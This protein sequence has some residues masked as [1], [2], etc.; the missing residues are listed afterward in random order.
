[1]NECKF[2]KL[3]AIRVPQKFISDD[4]TSF[5]ATALKRVMGEWVIRCKTVPSY[6]SM[7]NG[8]AGRMVGTINRSI[9]R[10]L[11]GAESS[12]DA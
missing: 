3:R 1:M 7:S 10:V 8:K 11:Q 9:K 2:G 5:T 6:A 12:F 4:P